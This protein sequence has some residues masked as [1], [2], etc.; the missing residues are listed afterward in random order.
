METEGDTPTRSKVRAKKELLDAATELRAAFW[1]ALTRTWRAR[2][3]GSR[4][5]A[6][7]TLSLVTV[8]DLME[9]A[10]RGGGE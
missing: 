8:A 5:T 2:W 10:R 1:D 7:V 4:S 6:I 9:E 3:T